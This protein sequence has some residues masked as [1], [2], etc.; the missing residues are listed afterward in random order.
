MNQMVSNLYVNKTGASSS[1]QNNT[2]VQM[3]TSPK[4]EDEQQTKRKQSTE[5]LVKR[6]KRKRPTESTM[7]NDIDGRI[8]LFF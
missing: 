5:K 6:V 4:P 8:H 2:N 7:S 1:I 3:E